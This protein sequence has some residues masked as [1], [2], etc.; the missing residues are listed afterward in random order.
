MPGP[1]P[2]KTP[3]D[4]TMVPTLMSGAVSRTDAAGDYTAGHVI[5]SKY[6]LDRVLGEG[7][8]GA[9]WLARNEV[10]DVDVA[11]KLIRHDR[12]TEEASQ[13]LLQEARATAR[14]GH[15]SIVRIFDYGESERGDPFIVMELLRGEPLRRVLTRKR[16]LPVASAVQ[17]LLPVAGALQAAHAKGIVHRDV[18]PENLFI[19][20]DERGA[21]IPKVVDFGIAKLHREGLDRR[22]TQDGI[23]L[24]SPDY[25]SPEQARGREDID[26]RTDIWSLSVV[27]YETI[28]GHIPFEGTSYNALLRAIVE[29]APLPAT[30]LCDADDELWRIIERG[31]AKDRERRWPGMQDLGKALARW[32]IERSVTTDIT[33]ASIAFEW[34]AEG[35]RRPF[36]EPPQLSLPPAPALPSSESLRLTVSSAPALPHFETMPLTLPSASGLLRS[37]ATLEGLTA[38]PAPEAEVPPEDPPADRPD[39]QG[40]SALLQ[41]PGAPSPEDAASRPRR[42]LGIAFAVLA[43]TVGGLLGVRARLTSKD[44]PSPPPSTPAALAPAPSAA[45]PS[46]SAEAPPAA[47]PSA[48]A[49]AP[50]AAALPAAPSE[51]R[52][53]DTCVV[54]QLP[55][56]AFPASPRPDFAWLCAETD[57]RRGASDFKRRVV[58]AAGGG[59]TEAM[60]E[61]AQLQWYEM[62]SFAVLRARCCPAPA[63][64]A[65]PLPMGT[66][67]PLARSLDALGAAA[68]GRGD[69]DAALARYRAAI[70]CA[71]S[72]GASGD[73]IYRTRPPAAAEAAL[74]R[75]LDRAPRPAAPP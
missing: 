75:T 1:P 52:P 4:E 11:V 13:R 36:S 48:S 73:Y 26:E 49:E 12:A 19:T 32:A 10:L 69:V 16:R 71:L 17:T 45:P 9:V 66:C 8:M 31:L 39:D 30:A 42:R 27:L 41:P 55:P 65:L 34:L 47:P 29:D 61:W 18:K 63:P 51:A 33:G 15:P 2:R 22:F 46:A 74:R 35:T 70:H 7:G 59:V 24:G 62:A 6:R 44:P 43:L 58:Q 72:S 38:P 64:L 5:A 60:R 57:P 54:A 3:P 68:A 53:L 67:D 14:I 21:I 40:A 50:P 37:E 56:D 23:V 25:M 20:T 28:T